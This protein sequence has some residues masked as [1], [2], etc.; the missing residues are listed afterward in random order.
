MRARRAAGA[1]EP[2]LL[3]ITMGDPA[4]V[5]PEIAVKALA[6]ERVQGACRPL[7][8]GSAE[9]FAAAARIVGSGAR[10]VPF[11]DPGAARW[12]PEYVN[13][14]A[15]RGGAVGGAASRR[16]VGGGGSRPATTPS[17][18]R[19]TLRSPVRPPPR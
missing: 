3:A 19:W 11:T 9:V 4:G 12:G 6:D 8:V 10:I 5:G 15:Q 17:R 18:A 2:P 13:V 7:L 1:G 14:A 16:G